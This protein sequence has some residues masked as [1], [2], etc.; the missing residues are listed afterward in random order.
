MDS[1]EDLIKRI[2]KALNDAGV[3]YMLTCMLAILRYTKVDLKA[4]KRRAQR[5]N[6]VSILEELATSD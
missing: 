3:D 2:A 5:E 1:F 4:V 6:T